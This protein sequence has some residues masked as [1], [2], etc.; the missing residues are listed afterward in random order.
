MM[1]RSSPLPAM[2]ALIL[3]CG[4]MPALAQ[5]IAPTP[6]LTPEQERLKLKVPEGFEVQ[7]VAAEPD[8]TK[9]MNLK[10]DAAGRLWVTH[11]VEYP[12]PAEG[13]PGR[14]GITILS[15]FGPDGR[16]RKIQRFAD[17]LNIPIGIVPVKDGCIVWSIPHIWKLT[18]TNGDGRADQ[19]EILFTGFEY[20]DTH[21][22]QNGFT[23]WIDG[24]IYACHGFRN[25]SKIRKG[26]DGPVV[27]EMQSG[28]AYRFKEDGSAI[29]QWTWGQVNPFGLTRWATS[30]RPTVTAAR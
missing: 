16:A 6:W 15:D 12:F 9:P 24:W 2:T 26:A 23:R 29:E 11:S 27:L 3:L 10:F 28:N 5:L 13:R 17:D 4:S 1:H 18:D 8:I 7:L 21:G 20:V 25:Q 19:R 30:T 14:D 22:N